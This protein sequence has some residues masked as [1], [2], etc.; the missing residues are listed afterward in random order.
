MWLQPQK[1][2]Q[3]KVTEAAIAIAVMRPSSSRQITGI[4][5]PPKARGAKEGTFPFDLL[6]AA[7]LQ[8]V[9]L[10]AKQ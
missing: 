2:Q 1:L 7:I 4:T 5:P 10:A 6:V 8:S 9:S 3:L